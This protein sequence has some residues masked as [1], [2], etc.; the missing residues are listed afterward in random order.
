MECIEGRVPGR[1][2]LHPPGWPLKVAR[3]LALFPWAAIRFGA[4]G[5]TSRSLASLQQLQWPSTLIINENDLIFG[6]RPVRTSIS[7]AVNEL[8]AWTQWD[9]TSRVVVWLLTEK[10][11]HADAREFAA[12]VEYLPSILSTASIKPAQPTPLPSPLQ[13]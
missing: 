3:S 10:R 9:G 6:G 8:A 4:S 11:V 7:L 2:R 5:G 13:L 1:I 12:I